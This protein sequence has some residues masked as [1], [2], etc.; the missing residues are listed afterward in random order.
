VTSSNST[1]SP[2]ERKEVR[3]F[4]LVAFLFF[5]SLCGLAV[6]R[7]KTA[8]AC[9]FG[10]LFLLGVCFLL[11]PTLSRPLYRGWLRVAHFIGRTITVLM[12]SLAYVLVITPSALVKRL[13]GGRPLPVKPDPDA[14][15]YWVDRTEPAQPR[16]RYLKRF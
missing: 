15:T 14:E 1:D 11:A 10:T 3:K 2:A 7:E 9:F 8:L 13:F 16:E 4:G 6:W 12:L 5:G